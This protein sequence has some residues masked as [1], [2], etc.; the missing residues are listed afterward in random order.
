MLKLKIFA[1][2]DFKL[3]IKLKLL[4]KFKNINKN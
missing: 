4:K 1:L 2:S 3:N